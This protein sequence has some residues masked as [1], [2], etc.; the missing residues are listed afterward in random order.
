MSLSCDEKPRPRGNIVQRCPI[1]IARRLNDF[2]VKFTH[3][4]PDETM[5]M[6]LHL[7]YTVF[8]NLGASNVEKMLK[9]ILS[10][11]VVDSFWIS[12]EEYDSRILGV[13]SATASD[14]RRCTKKFNWS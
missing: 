10:S 12:F 7:D 5:R 11:F 9:F 8:C 2:S 6:P 14:Y 3:C 13:K 1:V 4:A